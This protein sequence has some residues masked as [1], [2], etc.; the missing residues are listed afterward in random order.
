MSLVYDTSWFALRER[1]RLAKGETVFVMGASG[2]VGFAA[3]QLAKAMGARVLAGVSSPG[4]ADAV[5]AA[6]ADEIVDMSMPDLRE[7]LRARIFELTGGKGAD[8]IL[9]PLGGDFFDAAVRA[10]AWSGRLVVIGFASGRIP[11]IKANYI[12]VKNIEITGLQISDYR[13]RQP[14]RVA[15]CF[16]EIFHLYE[17][18]QVKPAPAITLP[19]EGFADAL[20]QIRDRTAKGR[21]VLTQDS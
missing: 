14:H 2:G 19:L 6:G 8:I 4:K 13:K 9:D 7:S 17:T 20:G 21:L 18:G 15:E 11:E 10:L 16:A 5:R 1:G 12:L 3:V